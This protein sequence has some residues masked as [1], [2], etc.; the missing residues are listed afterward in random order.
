VRPRGASIKAGA[1]RPPPALAGSPGGVLGPSASSHEPPD[2]HPQH[3]ASGTRSFLRDQRSDHVAPA[4]SKGGLPEL[5]L[6]RDTKRLLHN[7]CFSALC[8]ARGLVRPWGFCV[9]LVLGGAT[10]SN[11]HPNPK[12]WSSRRRARECQKVEPKPAF[13]DSRAPLGVP[14]QTESSTHSRGIQTSKPYRHVHH[15]HL[16][17]PRFALNHCPHRA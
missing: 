15:Q 8:P 10:T 9:L 7:Q 3:T 12:S 11:P 17:S 1:G 2:N 14:K 6:P 4:R 13:S 16:K 5:L